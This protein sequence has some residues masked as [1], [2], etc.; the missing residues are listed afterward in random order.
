MHRT[1]VRLFI[2]SCFKIASDKQ[3][4]TGRVPGGYRELRWNG[5]ITMVERWMNLWETFID[6][7]FGGKATEEFAM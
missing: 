3:E 4:S 7:C 2:E 6:G 5:G 1:N